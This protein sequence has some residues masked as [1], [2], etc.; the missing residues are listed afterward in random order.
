MEIVL[1]GRTVGLSDKIRRNEEL[2][3]SC[4]DGNT[5]LLSIEKDEYYAVNPIGSK[6]W[7]LIG[8]PQ[9]IS[10]ICEQLYQEYD[11]EPEMC[12]NEVLNF[13]NQMVEKGVIL[14]LEQN[15]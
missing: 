10:G 14:V 1:N 12:K 3:F 7:D 2:I 11:I 15:E 13:V 5:M 9:D 8:S 4:L 6:I